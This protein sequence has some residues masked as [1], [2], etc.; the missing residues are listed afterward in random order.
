MCV[1]VINDHEQCR[2]AFV[3]M[4]RSVV[5]IT[6]NNWIMLHRFTVQLFDSVRAFKHNGVE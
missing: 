4:I 2:Y 1:C 3:G 5:L 6:E